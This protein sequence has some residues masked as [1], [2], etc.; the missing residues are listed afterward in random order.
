MQMRCSTRA[1][2]TRSITTGV[3]V[4]PI[5]AAI[6]ALASS[7]FLSQT[8]ESRN[9]LHSDLFVSTPLMQRSAR[10]QGG[11]RRKFE[12]GRWYDLV[13]GTLT[14]SRHGRRGSGSRRNVC[15]GTENSS[16]CRR[17]TER[18]KRY[19][20]Q[21]RWSPRNPL[22]SRRGVCLAQKTYSSLCLQHS[23]QVLCQHK[24]RARYLH[25]MYQTNPMM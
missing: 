7:I 20:T 14:S 10:R 12:T 19:R 13:P 11:M 18:R 9:G 22:Q 6:F 16:R 2:T 3:L 5:S 24:N 17:G 15:D 25:S 8:T 4:Y 23:E 21:R 1:C